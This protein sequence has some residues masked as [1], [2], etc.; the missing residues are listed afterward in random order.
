MSTGK[1]CTMDEDL[2]NEGPEEIKND[3]E[4]A[5]NVGAVWL[6]ALKR[7]AEGRCS[8]SQPIEEL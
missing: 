6:V 4:E 7:P 8:L 3:D 2:R 5:G 1:G